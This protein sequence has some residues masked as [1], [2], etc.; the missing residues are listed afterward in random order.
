M[1]RTSSPISFPHA[2]PFPIQLVAIP[3]PSGHTRTI[4]HQLPQ[5]SSLP[6]TQRPCLVPLLTVL[7]AILPPPHKSSPY[8]QFPNSSS[9]L[10]IWICL[11]DPELYFHFFQ[12]KLAWTGFLP[13]P[14]LVGYKLLEGRKVVLFYFCNLKG[15]W[16]RKFKT[17]LTIQTG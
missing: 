6:G 3:P 17:Y 8:Q 4:Y 16:P 1:G 9:T 5:H 10:S 12:S 15:V 14:L 11:Q 2:V 13:A 7:P